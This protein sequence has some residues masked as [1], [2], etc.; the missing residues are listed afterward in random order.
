MQM[1]KMEEPK[2][3]VRSFSS[4]YDL[5]YKTANG[6]FDKQST[7]E[8]IRSIKYGEGE[9]AK[10]IIHLI[11]KELVEP[12]PGL[13]STLAVEFCDGEKGLV[14]ECGEG[15]KF[16]MMSEKE[17][18]ERFEEMGEDNLVNLI[19]QLEELRP[20]TGALLKKTFSILST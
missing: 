14:L 12:I 4:S 1:F 5:E 3:K 17:F 15:I 16:K 13:S 9:D 2:I 7:R 18:R 19:F 6:G 20:G 8:R 11:Y 10:K